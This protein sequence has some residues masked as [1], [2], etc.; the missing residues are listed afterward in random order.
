MAVS[1]EQLLDDLVAETRVLQDLV[2]ELDDAGMSTPTP[3]ERWSI[4]D[5]LTH[6]AYFD[7]TAT[8]AAVDPDTFRV[9]AAAL[10]AR[11]DDFPDQVAADHAALTA[12]EV[13]FWLA[14]TR[15]TLVA[16]F[17]GIEPKA[18]LPWYGPDMSA[19]S[20]VT[21]RLMETWAHGQDVADALGERRVP[22]DRLRHIAHLGVQTAGFSFLLNGR[23]APTSPVRVELEAPSGDRWEWG[24]E[25]AADRVTGTAHDFCLTVTQRRHVTDTALQVAGPVAT[26]WISIAQTF[27]GTPG[28]GRAPGAVAAFSGGKP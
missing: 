25:D 16:T 5:Q 17:R 23:A 28:T 27:A 9:E 6:L 11:G 20:S 14:E 26:E 1:M 3:A 7:E 10:V 12:D 18:R 4:R 24:P 13:R 2:A 22:T 19:L 15:T 21:A 8:L